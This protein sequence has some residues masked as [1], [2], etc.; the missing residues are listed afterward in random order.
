MHEIQ[1][2]ATRSP[3]LVITLTVNFGDLRSAM[4]PLFASFP[5]CTEYC[6]KDLITGTNCACSHDTVLSLGMVAMGRI[7]SGKAS[8]PPGFLRELVVEMSER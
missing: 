5:R 8:D 3:V 1:G 2:H 7:R 6:L 4:A